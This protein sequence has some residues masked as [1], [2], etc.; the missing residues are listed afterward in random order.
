MTK[1]VQFSLGLLAFLMA[2]IIA[3]LF[4]WHSAF[5]QSNS[6]H[7]IEYPDSAYKSFAPPYSLVT[8]EEETLIKVACDNDVTVLVDSDETTTYVYK[9]G[10]AW[11]GDSWNRIQYSGSRTSGNWVRGPAIK[12]LSNPDDT[13][14]YRVAAYVC[15][16]IGSSWK[17]GCKNSSCTN[18]T[19]QIQEYKYD[20]PTPPPSSSGGGG[21]SGGGS[22]SSGSS[23]GGSSSGGSNDDRGSAPPPRGGFS[24]IEV[25]GTSATLPSVAECQA[26]VHKSTWE[27]RPQNTPENNNTTD[28]ILDDG[29][30]GVNPSAQQYYLNRIAAV[31][32]ANITGTTDEL[33]QFF[34]C[35]WGVDDETTR[36]RA[37]M[38]STWDQDVNADVVCNGRGVSWG[39]LQIQNK[40]P[41]GCTPPVHDHAYPDVFVST[42]NNLNYALAWVAACHRG[43]MSQWVPNEFM[44]DK[45]RRMRECNGLWFSGSWRNGN[46]SYLNNLDQAIQDKDW[47]VSN[48]KDWPIANRCDGGTCDTLPRD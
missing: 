10:Y 35:Y 18:K 37:R 31:N 26:R 15:Q 45:E 38:E 24:D 3:I 9:Y 44:G 36:A 29:V 22:S 6:C 39:L 30:D 43:D 4:S 28:L 8:G 42:G 7:T 16:R 17:C 13:N 23:G 33:I 32:N 21:S 46:S 11:D 25:L 19:W 27:P 41:R 2:S 48:Y 12:T 5:A 34:S 47:L 20:A 40:T 14:T 1:R